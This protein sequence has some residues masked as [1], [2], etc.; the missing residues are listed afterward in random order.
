MALVEEGLTDGSPVKPKEP[1]GRTR[2]A[3]PPAD[4]D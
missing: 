2:V 1:L 4:D 3:E